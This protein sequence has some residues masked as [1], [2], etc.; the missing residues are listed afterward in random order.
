MTLADKLR[1]VAESGANAAQ[2]LA[3]NEPELMSLGRMVTRDLRA[4]NHEHIGHDEEMSG[5]RE[6]LQI[7]DDKARE[8]ANARGKERMRKEG[9]G[10]WAEWHRR[11]LALDQVQASGKTADEKAEVAWLRSFV[12]RI[13]C[14]SCKTKT[15]E[16]VKRLI[17]GKPWREGLY[18]E[19]TVIFHNLVNAEK[20]PAT[21]ELSID[22]AR[23]IWA[24]K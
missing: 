2:M 6:I 21:R 4:W 5:L 11:A 3:S 24:G 17:D 10:L 23:I 8:Q 12:A 1:F 16:C 13:P 22:E 9:P 18:F 14:G 7:A 15:A 20:D 19:E